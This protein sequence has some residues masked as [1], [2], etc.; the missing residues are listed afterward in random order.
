MPNDLSTFLNALATE[1][2]CL[3]VRF[4]MDSG[5]VSGYLAK[6]DF[7]SDPELTKA[8]QN[9]DS[10]F[11]IMEG[12]AGVLRFIGNGAIEKALQDGTTQ[13]L[14]DD[15]LSKIT[16]AELRLRMLGEWRSGDAEAGDEVWD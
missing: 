5:T 7:A 1:I 11:Q 10:A 13:A 14:L 6:T 12:I 16:I 4:A 15:A 8:L 3:A 9:S 2:G